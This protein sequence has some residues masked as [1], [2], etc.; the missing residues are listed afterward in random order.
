VIGGT[1]AAGGRANVP[2]LWGAA[3]LLVLSLTMLNSFGAGAGVRP[4]LTGLVIV[5]VIT[6]AG[7]QKAPAE[8][9]LSGMPERCEPDRLLSGGVRRTI[10]SA[11]IRNQSRRS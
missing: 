4:V 7:G 10:R 2:G 8:R 9:C 11:H 5:A 6:A 3:P 1:S